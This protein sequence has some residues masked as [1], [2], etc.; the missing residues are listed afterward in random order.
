MSYTFN[1]W[2]D[3]STTIAANSSYT[4]TGN[5][6]FTAKWI[7]SYHY[8]VTA[9]SINK[10]ASISE[11]TVIFKKNDGTTTQKEA[12]SSQTTTYSFNG[13]YT[14]SSGGTVKISTNGGNYRTFSGENLYA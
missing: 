3:G 8:I 10:N 11:R 1:G 6:T 7:E 5:T 4:P 13:W 14:S 9:P 12:T 2:N